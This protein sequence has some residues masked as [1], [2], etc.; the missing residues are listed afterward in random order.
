[1]TQAALYGWARISWPD[2]QS[3]V[4][5]LLLGILFI[6]AFLRRLGRRSH[7]MREFSFD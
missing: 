3:A 1:M 4:P 2:A 5:D 7:A 6:V